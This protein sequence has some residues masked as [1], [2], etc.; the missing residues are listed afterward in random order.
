MTEINKA[1][2]FRNTLVY[3]SYQEMET[4]GFPFSDTFNKTLMVKI[5]FFLS[6]EAFLNYGEVKSNEWIR[7]QTSWGCYNFTI[8]H[9]VSLL[10][11]GSSL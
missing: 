2:S 3:D 6:K 8:C 11:S 7:S 4:A 1:E 10:E 9:P 5:N